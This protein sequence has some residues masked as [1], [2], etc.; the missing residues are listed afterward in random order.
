[1]AHTPTCTHPPPEVA[2][3]QVLVRRGVH[4]QLLEAA[5]EHLRQRAR[6]AGFFPSKGGDN[7]CFRVIIQYFAEQ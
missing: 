3:E 1:M 7:G 4:Q 6:R 2:A 5:E